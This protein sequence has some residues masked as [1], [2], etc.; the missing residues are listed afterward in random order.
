MISLLIP[1]KGRPDKLQQC[2]KSIDIDCE[3]FVMATC[4]S[5]VTHEVLNRATVHFNSNLTVIQSQNI[6]ASIC[7]GS[8]FPICDDVEFDPGS[9]SLLDDM[10]SATQEWKAFGANVTNMNHSKYGFMCI[11][12]KL[13]EHELNKKLFFPKYKHFYA[14]TELGERLDIGGHYAFAEDVTMR[15]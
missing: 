9:L 13:F 12:K 8:P 10:L 14:D 4:P 3:I 2:I 6:L 5:D 15:H 7:N 1:T 11:G